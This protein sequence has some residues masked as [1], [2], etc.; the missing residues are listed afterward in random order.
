M[1]K[2]MILVICGLSAMSAVF[3]DDAQQQQACVPPTP[4]GGTSGS[5]ET[6]QSNDPNEITGPLGEGEKRYVQQ[7]EWMDYT[8]YFEN[9]TNATAAAQEIFVDLPMDENLDWTTL[10]LGEIAF[11]EHIDTSL[12]GKSHGKTSYPLPGTNTFVKTEVKVTEKDGIPCLSWYMRDWDPTTADNFPAS[13]TGGFLPPN[14]P[15]TH[16]GEGHL[17]YRVRVRSDAT[18]DTVIR[19]SA[20]IVFDNNPMIE[21][22]P[23]W[24]NTVGKETPVGF[25][26]S[27][28]EVTAN[29][30]ETA[31]IYVM[32]GNATNA[33]GVKL[34]LT[35]N[36]AVAADIDV[37]KGKVGE[38]TPK[39]GLKF[40]IALN[41][42][43]GEVGEKVITIPVKTDKAVEDDESFTLQLADAQGMELGEDRVC[44]VTIH[45]PGYDALAAK[46][47][48]GSASKAEKSAWEKLQ[49]AKAPYIRGLAD[50]ANAGKVKG[51]GLCAA[52]KKVTLKATANKGWVFM[53]WTRGGRGATALPDDGD[54]GG[55]VATTPSLV[56]DRSAK[57]G[58]DSATST[59]ITNVTGDATYYACFITSDEDKA[60]ISLAVNGVE[61]VAAR[62]ESAPYLTNVWCGVYLEWPVAASALSEAKVKVAGLPTGLKF[63][64]KP[65]TAKIGTGKNAVTVTNVLANTIYGAPTAASK[66]DTKTGVAKPSAVKVTV[67]TAGKSS[68]T[69]QIDATVMPLPAWAQGTFAGEVSAGNGEQG[70]GNG[71]LGERALPEGQ[72]SL[73]IDAK[74]KISG[75]ALGDGLAYTL[76]A[77]YYS[78]F[79]A[80]GDGECVSSNFLADVTASWSYK[81]GSKTIKTNDVVRMTVQDNGIGG[82]A[83]GGPQS[84]AAAADGDA[85]GQGLAALPEWTAWQYN[86]KVEPW[87]TLGKKFDKTTQVYAIRK[88]GSFIDG[89]EAATVALGEEVTGCV[90]LKFTASGAAS[91]SGEFVTGYDEKKQKYATVKAT[92]SATLVPMDEE[93]VS[94][95]IYLTP[96]GLDPHAR[97][98]DVQWPKE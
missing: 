17:S 57:P 16:C 49:K 21:T 92:G 38:E 12:S 83:M 35:Y 65:V 9:K 42:A 14:D 2:L 58:K 87:K 80:I 30:G 52:G 61:M 78:G 67:T 41:W 19:A 79:T 64:D 69:Y 86:W 63:T 28:P 71:P 75:K 32:G 23:S 89:D 90:T 43:A 47:A 74:G 60:N 26:F 62:P 31:T 18:N 34:Y 3:A 37:K 29:E 13:A 98:L 76:A 91:V 70:T 50:P 7:G 46:I 51:S 77:P 20:Q 1:K 56:I 15:E 44:T 27:S 39:G 24:W 85:G 8:I 59:T 97:C 82:V 36:T 11:G 10:E 81:E 40:P 73:T 33:V 53:G 96:K 54:D 94:V 72:V 45:D 25:I 95:F 84:S 68:Q 66:I 5:G 48:D 55:F 22:D 88:D 93:T 6:K 4:T